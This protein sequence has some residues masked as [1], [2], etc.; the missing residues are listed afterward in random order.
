MSL[1][2]NTRGEEGGEYGLASHRSSSERRRTHR[3]GGL[4]DT[5]GTTPMIPQPSYF[6]GFTDRDVE[7]R[8]DLGGQAPVVQGTGTSVAGSGEVRDLLLYIAQKVDSLGGGGAQ[9]ATARVSN[10]RV[11]HSNPSNSDPMST[12][13]WDGLSVSSPGGR[14]QNV[15]AHVYGRPAPY[16]KPSTSTGGPESRQNQHTAVPIHD[17]RIRKRSKAQASFGSSAPSGSGGYLDTQ[18]DIRD[19]LSHFNLPASAIASAELDKGTGA[20]TVTFVDTDTANRV[21]AAVAN[22][23]RCCMDI[24][25]PVDVVGIM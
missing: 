19:I 10:S 5:T 13:R 9:S 24:N 2:G 23:C 20:V 12:G 18:L 25:V 16:T 8:G 3:V 1:L 21:R 22:G 7:R 15:P 4:L 11:Q 6:S 14:Q 17:A